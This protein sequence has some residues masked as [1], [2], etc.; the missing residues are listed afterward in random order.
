L[1]HEYSHRR[2][3]ADATQQLIVLFAQ[4]EKNP[5]LASLSEIPSPGGPVEKTYGLHR[6]ANTDCTDLAEPAV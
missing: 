6:K 4:H 2:P 3:G 1:A 5:P